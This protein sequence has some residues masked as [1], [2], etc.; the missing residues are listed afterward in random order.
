MVMFSLIRTNLMAQTESFIEGVWKGNFQLEF[1]IKI[2]QDKWGNLSAKFYIP[3]Q[4]V[5]NLPINDVDF[6]NDS[7]YLHF[8]IS[9]T[10]LM[11]S[12]LSRAL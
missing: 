3:F 5:Y 4:E 8:N 7:L 11:A 1:Q 10:F 2:D 12:Y 9:N 6:K